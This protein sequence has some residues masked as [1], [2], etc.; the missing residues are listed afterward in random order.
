MV[1]VFRE[2]DEEVRRDQ[3]ASLWSKY[4][5]AFVGA[6]VLLVGGV[7]GWRYTEY[8]ALKAA[9]AAGASLDAAT[10]Q[11]RDPDSAA[12]GEKALAAI[13]Q[14]DA[15]G[16]AT[17]ARFRAA[18]AQG[19]NDASAA[20][21]SFDAL[22][23]DTTLDETL[24][25]L[26]RL[27]AAMLRVDTRPYAEIRPALEPLAAPTAPWR[28][29]ARELLGVSALKAGEMDEAGRWF[30]QLVTDPETPVALK[31]RGDLYLGLVRSGPVPAAK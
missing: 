6:A 5:I 2:V 11:L 12:D 14:G 29:T 22:A 8:R 18:S 16:Y 26:A 25:S 10:R 15:K 17:I 3:L 9:E 13:A 27:R 4:S 1:D 19:R 20:A 31:Q 7:A 30:D 24:R 23:A 21:A 28:H